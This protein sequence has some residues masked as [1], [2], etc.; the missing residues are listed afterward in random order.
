[1]ESRTSI[2]VSLPERPCGLVRTV[3]KERDNRSKDTILGRKIAIVYICSMMIRWMDGNINP[4]RFL[5][6]DRLNIFR[7]DKEGVHIR[8]WVCSEFP[9]HVIELPIQAVS[10][11]ESLPSSGS[12]RA[13]TSDHRF[14]DIWC[15][16][17]KHQEMKNSSIQHK[18]LCTKSRAL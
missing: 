14:M 15:S 11:I 18:D 12:A 1:M 8:S 16:T 13:M 2:I 3:A 10:C 17:W 6:Y 4:Y 9:A 7:Q 5:P